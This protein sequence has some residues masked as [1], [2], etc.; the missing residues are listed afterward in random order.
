MRVTKRC[1]TG[2]LRGEAIVLRTEAPEVIAMI[3]G[4]LS[5]ALQLLISNL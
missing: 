5:L 2:K 4:Q 1:R 3:E